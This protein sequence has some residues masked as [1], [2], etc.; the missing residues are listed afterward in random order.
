MGNPV[1]PAPP[2]PPGFQV[3]TT[4]VP[5]LPAER[6]FPLRNSD[7]LILCEGSGGS[8]KSGLFL[9]IGLLGGAITGIVSLVSSVDIPAALT[10]MKVFWSF[11][12]LIFMAAGS[13][14]G[15]T[16]FAIRMAKESNAYTRLKMVINTF[17][18]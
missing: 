2:L 16:I 4:V 12:V 11:V 13:S 10:T 8:E 18:Q 6:A 17:F 9:C 1:Q 14:A 7:F 5:E 15:L 3:A